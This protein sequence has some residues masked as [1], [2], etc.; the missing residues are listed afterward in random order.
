MVST[1]AK[2]AEDAAEA[3]MASAEK[4]GSANAACDLVE[5]V[6]RAALEAKNRQALVE[7]APPYGLYFMRAYYGSA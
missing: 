1:A 2:R 3:E 4:E 7:K 6:L 5:C